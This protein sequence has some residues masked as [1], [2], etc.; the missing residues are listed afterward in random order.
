MYANAA[1]ITAISIG[2]R[3]APEDPY[4]AP[5]NDCF[6]A[7]EYLV[8]HA[9]EEF[10]AKVLFLSG[11]SAGACLATLTA[12]H[13]MRSRPAH[14]LVGLIL[15]FGSFDLTLSMPHLVNNNRSL[16]IDLERMHRF[17]DAYTPGMS[18]EERRRPSVSPMY[19]DMQALALSSPHKS[20]PP[21]LFLCGTQ[22]PLLDDTLMMSLKWMAAGGEAIVKLYP[23]AA[24]GF[25]LLAQLQLAKEAEEVQAQ[26]LNEKMKSCP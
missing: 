18:I 14:R 4:P 25:T 9:E 8:D 7:A 12:F 21:A 23:G 20:L 6:D 16:V 24:H 19:E 15:L 26:F 5:T 1:Q 3:L 10:G 13:L 17:I 2:Y 22:D 11:E